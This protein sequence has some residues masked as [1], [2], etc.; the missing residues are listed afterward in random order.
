MRGCTTAITNGLR[1]LVIR[2][3]YC[4][5]FKDRGYNWVVIEAKSKDRSLLGKY[6]STVKRHGKVKAVLETKS[7]VKNSSVRLSLIEGYDGMI[8]SLAYGM[9]AI[10]KLKRLKMAKSP[11]ALF[12]RP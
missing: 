9:G 10:Q 1:D 11:G 2:M 5:P 4:H 8:S 3:L 6:V 7:N 12:Y